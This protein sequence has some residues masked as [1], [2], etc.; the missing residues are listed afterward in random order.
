MTDQAN[1]PHRAQFRPPAVLDWFQGQR[2]ILFSN[3]SIS[4]FKDVRN[5]LQENLAL[6]QVQSCNLPELFRMIMEKQSSWMER[7]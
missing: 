1:L 5:V 2:E 4:S 6:D 7:F 3:K